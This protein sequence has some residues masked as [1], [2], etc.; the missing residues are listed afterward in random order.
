MTPLDIMISQSNAK[1]TRVYEFCK[2]QAAD[3]TLD[4][5][6]R[7]SSEYDFGFDVEEQQIELSL[8]IPVNKILESALNKFRCNDCPQW[9]IGEPKYSVLTDVAYYYCQTVREWCSGGCSCDYVR[10]YYLQN[11]AKG[12]E[13]LE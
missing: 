4:N 2:R 13:A 7:L 1:S 5:L 10:Q 8:K 6:Y 12:E 11:I 9:R 3:M